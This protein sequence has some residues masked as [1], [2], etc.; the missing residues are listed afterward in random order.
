V[1][2]KTGKVTVAEPTDCEKCYTIKFTDKEKG[3]AISIINENYFNLSQ[4][5]IFLG[6]TY[7]Y[8]SEIG[9]V[10][11]FYN[12]IGTV[13]SYKLGKN[14]LKFFYNDKKNYLLYKL[15]KQ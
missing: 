11:L 9:N 2:N 5:Q 7:A 4:E 6:A 8:D 10:R 13:D 15:I 12:A 14:E 3:I 1:D